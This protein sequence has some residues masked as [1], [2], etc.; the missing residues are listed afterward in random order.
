MR[1]TDISQLPVVDATTGRTLGILDES[2]VLV[3]VH[4]D[5]AGF[6]APVR[7]AM[8]DRLETLSP[9]AGFDQLLPVF[10]R[11][12]VAIVMDGHRF[13]GLITRSDLLAFLRRNL[14]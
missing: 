13:L 14:P 10:D 9:G 12:R 4:A 2:D 1:A 7:A 8:S 5:P 11:G 6:R 3:K